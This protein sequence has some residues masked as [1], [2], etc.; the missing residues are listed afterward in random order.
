MKMPSSAPQ[1]RKSQQRV[2]L[3]KDFHEVA[4]EC[5]ARG[6][7]G[8]KLP[9][10][11]PTL[12]L[13]PVFRGG[14]PGVPGP[15]PFFRAIPIAFVLAAQTLLLL[16]EPSRIALQAR[17]RNL[18]ESGLL[19]LRAGINAETSRNGFRGNPDIELTTFGFA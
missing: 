17:R 10:H 19:A 3:A 14:P 15:L 11:N 18:R 16:R 9:P 7:S 1:R 2:Q 6:G 4:A 5:L 8:A 12:Q 13:L